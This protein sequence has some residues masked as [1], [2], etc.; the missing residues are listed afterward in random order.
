MGCCLVWLDLHNIVL[1]AEAMMSVW[2]RKLRIGYY[3][4]FAHCYDGF[5]QL[6]SGDRSAALRE[7]LAGAGGISHG[8][9]VLDLC[10]GT[11]AMLPALR[12]RVGDN[13]RV[14]GV[15]FSPGM[16]GRARDR[17]AD[18]ANVE[19]Y[20]VDV[21]NLPFADD[22]FDGATISHAFYE[23][24]GHD[25]DKFLQETHRVLK[26]GRRFVMM[27]HEVPKLTA[28]RLLY[29]LRVL[30]MGSAKTLQILRHEREHF[31]R[32]FRHVE[33]RLASSGGSKIY[34]CTK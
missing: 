28:V 1:A 3:D 10:T 24:K 27:E 34:V 5:I 23:L 33:K 22:T 25:V 31:Q 11:G 16:L 21:I 29:Y 26:P 30:S 2:W 9:T 32:V 17:M 18:T 6:H 7:E 15:D 14:V 12:R 20:E 13:G 8:D 19:L 4:A